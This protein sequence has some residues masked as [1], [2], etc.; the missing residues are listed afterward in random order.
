MAI[1]IIGWDNSSP[2]VCSLFQSGGREGEGALVK[3]LHFCWIYISFSWSVLIRMSNCLSTIPGI[4]PQRTSIPSS[5]LMVKACWV[6]FAEE[7]KR[8]WLSATAHLI[9]RMP[10]LFFDPMG[11][12]FFGQKYTVEQAATF[13]QYL[14]MSINDFNYMVRKKINP[15]FIRTNYY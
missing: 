8:H 14:V 10:V 3:L 12:C 5:M 4:V 6:R 1:Q 13:P 9:W 2:V 7:R 11:R 15:R